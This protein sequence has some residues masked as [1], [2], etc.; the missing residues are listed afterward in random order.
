VKLQV[1]E[2]AAARG[3]SNVK[4]AT[5][6]AYRKEVR[7]Q[8]GKALT[9]GQGANLVALA[10]ACSGATDVRGVARECSRE[11]AF[12]PWHS[13]TCSSGTSMPGWRSPR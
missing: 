4:A 12:G 3:L 2:A 13:P 8:T 11:L 5:L 9:A 10:G 6:E 7:A 1:A